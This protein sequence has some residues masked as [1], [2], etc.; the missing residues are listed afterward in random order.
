MKKW[1]HHSPENFLHKYLL[2]EAE[3]ARIRKKDKKAIALYKYAISASMEAGYHQE[4]AIACECL[5]SF[6]LDHGIKDFAVSY[7]AKARGLY[8][9]WG[10]HAKV[11]H[12]NEKY[13]RLFLS[14]AETKALSESPES[15]GPSPVPRI[16]DRLDIAAIMKISQAISSEIELEKL[17]ATLIRVITENSGAQKA[18]LL[19]NRNGRFEIDAE[20]G[21]NAEKITVL[22]GVA[23]DESDALC[24]GIVSYVKRTREPLFIDD[25]QT[26]SRFAEDPYIRHHSVRSLLC[27]PL[28]RQQHVIGLIYLENNL[29]PN[30]FTPDRVEMITMLSTQAANCL[31]NAIFFE[32]TL[33]AE[34]T[35]KQQRE[36]YQKLVETM[37]DGVG[38]V[39]PQLH[40]TFVNNALCRMT[41]YS[42]EEL[43]EKAVIDLLDDVNQQRLEEEVA[44]W[45]DKER[46]VFE[47]DWT[48]RDGALIS[49]ILSPKPI[50]NDDG[51]FTGFLG[52][53][54]DVTDLKQAQ[55]EKEL[56][57]A[58]LI[59]A[60]KMEA[61][62][63]LAGGVAHDFNNYLTTI[64]GS[65]DL[66]NFKKN[67]PKNLEK[68]IAQIKNAAQLS[69]ALTGQL[70]AF[71]RRQ[72]LE[73]TAINLNTIVSNIQK[74]L[75]RLIGENIQLT[76]RLSP[77]LKQINA[78]FGQME[79]IVM[80]LAVNARDA[81]P[82][83]G[84]LQLKTEN[85][86]IDKAY[87]HQTTYAIP[88]EYV[89][90]T[91]ED[92]GAGMD[93]EMMDKIFDPFFSTKGPGHGT[94]L[95]LSVVY[96]VVKQHQGWIN[97]YSEPNHGTTF[98]VYLPVLQEA[99]HLSIADENHAQE[100]EIAVYKGNQERILLIEDQEEVRDVVATA[101]TENGYTVQE[102]ATI[103]EARQW[104]ARSGDEFDLLFS[105][106]ILPD[107]NGIDFA[108]QAS[109]QHPA[110][111]VLISSGYT[112][113]KSRSDVI[114]RNRFS[115]LQKPY[116]LHKMLELLHLIFNQK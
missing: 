38:I 8:Q 42:F 92:S 82:A 112:E 26:N 87:C 25:A 22:Q 53:V 96:G 14:I 114:D 18:M 95:G 34:K 66:I 83:G 49:T 44:N 84:N 10:S 7:M 77:E 46:H 5:G 51:D 86:V 31:E 65:V 1:A 16:E 28:I 103:D 30:A 27:L 115:F 94:G 78:D 35:A 116:P 9:S 85:V 93:R 61:I 56:A 60:Q 43:T 41:G 3:R 23:V 100:P 74:M 2:V 64:L 70:L 55:R 11:Q 29:T 63:M 105:D 73:K 108:E 52:I 47:I 69:A 113:E 37:N 97:V 12:L 24:T 17:L 59:Q 19:L 72:M 33:A 80:N 45:T 54:T 62:G 39:D 15:S 6:Y 109:S 111:K 91:V 89:C 90:L 99:P 67:L 81:M 58:Q 76:T 98:K 21:D 57:Q 68:H 104:M 102:A 75:D 110:L 106:V 107:G 101:L 48:A 50:Y 20:V 71:G 13:D 4:A 40:I 32:K 79:Q 36:Q 88:G